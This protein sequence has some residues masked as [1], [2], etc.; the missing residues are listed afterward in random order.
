[1]ISLDQIQQLIDRPDSETGIL[2]V[3]LDM[4]VNENQKRT[5][6]IFLNKEKAR[7]PELD[8]D[9]SGHHQEPI[10]AA[11][12]RVEEWLDSE[13]DESKKGVV[14]FTEVDGEWL[15]AYQ[16]SV[17]VQNRL[18]VYERP[19]VAPLVE[20]FERYHHHGVVLVDREHLRLMSIFLDQTLNEREVETE[21]Y[22]APHDIRRGGFSAKDYQDRK[23]EETRHFFKEFAEEVE[24]FV[25]RHE[26]DDL[27]L[28]GTHENVQKFREFLPDT[29]RKLISYTDRMDIEASAPEIQERLAPVFAA[30]LEEEEARVVQMLRERVQ[31]AHKAVA[32][33]DDTLRELQ[34]GK[35]EALVISNELSDQ[36]GRCNSCG[37]FLARREGS[38]PYCGGSVRDAVN[39]CEAMVRMAA[40]Q[41]IAIDFVP[42]SAVGELGGVGGLV[43]F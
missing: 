8:S 18:E 28:L 14:V 32:G 1:M 5:H 22:P 36:G 7:F 26:P 16:L 34:E 24:S 17:P 10:G 33:L 43:R 29:V 20:V 40:D 39:L 3:Y 21:P 38:C 11:F 25:R 35:L 41:G 2:S 9:R 27:I 37:F 15:E 4:S 31:Q 6:Q 19:I 30:R 12:E 13:Y 42:P 23:A